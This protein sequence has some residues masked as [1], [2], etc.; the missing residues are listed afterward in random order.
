M[1]RPDTLQPI[2]DPLGVAAI[3]LLDLARLADRLEVLVADLAGRRGT[4]DLALLMECQIADLLS[5]RLVGVS[6]FLA[7][8]AAAAPRDAKVDVADAVRGLALSDQ[9]RCLAALTPDDAR[10]CGD[11]EL[12][13]FED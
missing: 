13:L 1:T 9:A 6:A 3:E 2:G 11:G 5:Q 4:S 7:A 8:L 12:T 10:S